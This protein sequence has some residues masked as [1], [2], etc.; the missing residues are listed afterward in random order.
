M[1]KAIIKNLAE[2]WEIIELRM[3]NRIDR[4]ITEIGYRDR[5]DR[6]NGYFSRHLLTELGDIELNVPRMRKFNAVKVIRR[7]SRRVSH[8][9][10]LILACFVPGLSRW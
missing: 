5:T 8:V 7:Y 4:Y 3:K 9:S 2:A 6:R 1:K 10:R